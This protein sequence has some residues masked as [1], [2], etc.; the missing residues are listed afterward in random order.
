MWRRSSRAFGLAAIAAAVVI[1]AAAGGAAACKLTDLNC[2]LRPSSG[3]QLSEARGD[4]GGARSVSADLS[5]SPIVKRLDYPTDFDFL[6]DGQMIVALR[7]G[8][9]ERVDQ[10]G[11]VV[12]KP[13]LDLRKRVNISGLRGLMALVLDPSPTRPLHFYVVYSMIDPAH[14]SPTSGRPTTVR[15][16]R[17][18]M[19]DGVA[20]PTSEKVIEGRVVGGSCVSRPTTNCIPSDADHIGADIVVLPDHTLLISTGDGGPA[21]GNVELAQSTTSLGGKVL[22]VDQN[23]HGLPSNPFWNGDP[24]ANQSKVWAYGFRNPF[25]LSS[26]SGGVVVG[27]VGFNHVEELD[28]VKPGGDYGWPCYEGPIQTPEYRSKSFCQAYYAAHPDRRVQPWFALPQ[29]RW[30]TVIAGTSLQ[31]ARELPPSFRTQYAF[32]DWADSKVWVTDLATT[33]QHFVSTKTLHLVESGA[34]GPVRLRVGPEGA[35]YE[36][37]IN[38]G[39]IWRFTAKAH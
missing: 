32:A 38:T 28:L 30:R 36:L 23:G 15:V 5:A 37:A 12:P 9:I 29:P 14:P 4:L 10:R 6:P 19:V 18:T 17:F 7:N 22:R 39:E 35:L 3:W 26:V 25:R 8:L 31:G 16:S 27:D 20:S 33:H 1:V 21:L 11:H 24:N 34:A 13:V 2:H